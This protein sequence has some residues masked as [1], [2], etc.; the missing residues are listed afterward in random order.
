MATAVDCLYQ[1]KTIT[2]DEA[3]QIKKRLAGNLPPGA[4]TCVGCGRPVNPHQLGGNAVAHFEH[5]E[6]NPDCDLSHKLPDRG[7]VDSKTAVDSDDWSRDE[8]RASVEAYVDMQ[9]KHRVSEKFIKKRYYE[10]LSKRFGR[11]AKSFEYRMQ[12]ISYVLS[13]MGRQWLAGLRPAKNVGANV[14]SIIEALI[15]E[16]EGRKSIPVVAFEIS[17]RDDAKLPLFAKP[18]G[19]PSPTSATVEVTQ[20]QRDVQVKAWVLKHANGICECCRNHAPFKRVD[21]R[22]FLEVHHLHHLA[23]GGSDTTTNAVALCPNCHRQL[24]YGMN[25]GL[26]IESLFKSVSRLIS[27]SAGHG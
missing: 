2:V 3:L 7:K 17:V 25:A 8:L 14:A 10:D 9:R 24:H 5:M 26:L 23:D 4:F 19:N 20:Y 1:D 12:N 27:E 16:V 15:C 18:Q 21:G 11:T 22:P 6:R 13:L